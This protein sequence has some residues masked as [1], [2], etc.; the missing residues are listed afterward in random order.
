M[1][2]S[3]CFNFYG[4]IID[5]TYP[6]KSQ[7]KY[8]CGLRVVDPTAHI[9]DSKEDFATVQI[10]AKRIEDLPIVKRVGD[11]IRVHRSNVRIYP[12]RSHLTAGSLACFL[13][14]SYNSTKERSSS[15]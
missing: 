10:Y 13:H 8:L 1:D 7:S 5:A 4:V 2:N 14:L 11:I 12:L 9:T 3:E 6:Y 15:T